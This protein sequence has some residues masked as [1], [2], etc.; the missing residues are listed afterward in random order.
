MIDIDCSKFIFVT[1]IWLF[2]LY[3]VLQTPKHQHP[4]PHQHEQQPQVLPAGPHRVSDGLIVNINIY[5]SDFSFFYHLK[6]NRAASKFEDSHDSC[7]TKH[8]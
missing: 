3:E 8:L 4:H 5:S 6:T 7:D 1:C 2:V